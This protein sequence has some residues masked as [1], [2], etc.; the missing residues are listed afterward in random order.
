MIFDL[1]KS[2]E[3]GILKI[4][5]APTK[6]ELRSY[7]KEE[8]YKTTFD[9]EETQHY[10]LVMALAICWQMRK[11]VDLQIGRETIQESQNDYEDEINRTLADNSELYA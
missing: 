2:L 8:N 6:T 7:D 5:D 1:A 11:E 3:D 4:V 9:P 10:D